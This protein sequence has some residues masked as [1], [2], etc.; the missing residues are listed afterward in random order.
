MGTETDL[1]D[2]GRVHGGEKETWMSLLLKQVAMVTTGLGN[3]CFCEER[4]HYY[5]DEE[6]PCTGLCL[7]EKMEAIEAELKKK[8]KKKEKKETVGLYKQSKPKKNSAPCTEMC[9]LMRQR[10]G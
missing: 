8:Y 9:A 7:I 4:P 10:T 3:E 1:E 5:E 2:L 6:E